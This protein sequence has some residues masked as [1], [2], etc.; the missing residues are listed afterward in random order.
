[1]LTR[2]M[3]WRQKKPKVA[4]CNLTTDAHSAREVAIVTG[5]IIY[6][7]LLSLRP[8][9]QCPGVPQ[10]IQT[11][12]RISSFAMKHSWSRKGIT[13]SPQELTH[14]E[15]AWVKVM[16]P[17]WF[18]GS[19][20]YTLEETAYIATDASKDGWGFVIFTRTGEVIKN[21]SSY[22]FLRSLQTLTFT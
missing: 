15:L 11:L 10:T 21:P 6:G 22:L 20:D 12:R 14:L 16:N 7:Q 4:S 8:L 17:D 9:G 3:I 19:P 1:M 2:Q 13:L 5:R 18:S